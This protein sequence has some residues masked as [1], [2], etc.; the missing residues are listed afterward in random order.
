MILR[1][2]HVFVGLICV[3]QGQE[4]VVHG[5]KF[6]VA[7][8]TGFIEVSKIFPHRFEIRKKLVMPGFELKAWLV[9]TVD[10]QPATTPPYRA[11][12]IQSLIQ[13]PKQHYSPKDFEELARE[14]KNA[15]AGANALAVALDEM[16]KKIAQLS[17]TVKIGGITPIG[18]LSESKE[19][20]TYAI[21]MTSGKDGN[22]TRTVG[23]ISPCL[24]RGKIVYL[25][26]TARNESI[27]ELL[28]VKDCA[29][30]WVRQFHQ[31]NS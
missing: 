26:L 7:A 24:V 3:A 15:L 29:E 17:E 18:V 23:A 30:R 22:L 2:L 12:Q 20:L 10:G 21:L 13:Q 28:W 6:A 5:S 27:D 16:R 8:P 31:G 25:Y 19:H 4:I 14:I 9:E 1:H 11:L